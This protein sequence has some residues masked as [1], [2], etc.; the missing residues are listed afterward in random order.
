LA[1]VEERKKT[2]L[3]C[4]LSKHKL[5]T[6]DPH[7]CWFARGG[8]VRSEIVRQVKIILG[9]KHGLTAMHS[10]GFGHGHDHFI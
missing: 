7:W 3:K 2:Y 5:D 6:E 9:P 10:S 8:M 4:Y 1:V